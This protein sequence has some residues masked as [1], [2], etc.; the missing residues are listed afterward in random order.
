MDDVSPDDVGTAIAAAHRQVSETAV[1]NRFLD[2]LE[3]REVPRPRL[4]WLAGELHLLVQ[5]DRR[6]FALLA[7]R[8]PAPPAGDLYL[9]MAQAEGEAL[10]LV[11]DFA[12]AVG[13]DAEDL[14]TYEPRPLAQAYPA[15]LTRT[16]LFGTRSDVAMALLANAQGSGADYARAAD[17]LTSRYGLDEPAVGHFRYLGDTPQEVLDQAEDTLRAGLSD[18]DDPVAAVRCARMVRAY[19]NAFWECLAEGLG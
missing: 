10:R 6:S 19:E 14:R 4:G 5:S 16:A 1:P 2:L 8:F 12:V 13:M 3:R 9:A 11:D 18:G 7:A 17:A 15:H